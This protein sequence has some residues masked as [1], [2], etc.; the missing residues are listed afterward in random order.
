M[1]SI[2][3][4]FLLRLR[5]RINWRLIKLMLMV[6]YLGFM[7]L[8][9][10]SLI[11]HDLFGGGGGGGGGAGERRESAKERWARRN[12]Y[13]GKE[14]GPAP[15]EVLD[16]EALVVPGEGEDGKGVQLDKSVDVSRIVDKYA[17]NK[18]A[19]DRISLKR[20]LPD[21]R[22]ADCKTVEYDADLPTASVVVIFNN[23]RLS[24]LLRTVWSVLRMSPERLLHEVVLVDD[25]S[26]ITEIT[27]TLPLYMK[28]R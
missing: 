16:F 10:I 9:V 19:S 11:K 27:S 20:R 3:R 15:Q 2:T 4:L 22:H 21:V 13:P 12:A 8:V 1:A 18:L 17:F 24:A 23:E 6:L 5:H 7:L 26:N 25:G 28:Y 14:L